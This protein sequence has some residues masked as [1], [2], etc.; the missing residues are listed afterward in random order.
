MRNWLQNLSYKMQVF[1]QG[2]YG[3]DELTN[4]L[5]IAGIV[6]LILA[7]INPLH[8]FVYIAL[9]V[10]IYSLYRSYSK[11]H[12]ARIKELNFYL[13]I[14]VFLV[15]KFKLLKGMWRD[16]N[17]HI[18]VKCPNCKTYVRISKPAKGKT[19]RI[20]CPKCKNFFDKRT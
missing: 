16:R 10:L 6:F 15:N 19:I 3:R 8:F 14:K 18:Y 1:M 7:F 4:V 5:T 20:T 12:N 11:N 17:T 9:A 2:R 13:K